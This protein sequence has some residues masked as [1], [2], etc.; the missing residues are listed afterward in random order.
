MTGNVQNNI[1]L[2]SCFFGSIYLF[3]TS[4]EFVNRALLIKDDKDDK[5]P[6]KL[7][8]MINGLTMLV[9]GS[10]ISY[11]VYLCCLDIKK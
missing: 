11:G 4:L 9:S 1:I 5:V 6:N 10:I 7:F 8:M 3:S 2:S